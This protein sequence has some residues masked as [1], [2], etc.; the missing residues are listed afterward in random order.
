MQCGNTGT[1][2]GTIIIINMLIPQMN[3]DTFIVIFTQI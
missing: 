1:F 3:T 2:Y